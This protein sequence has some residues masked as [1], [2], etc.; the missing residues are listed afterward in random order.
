MAELVAAREAVL[1]A[2]L[3]WASWLAPLASGLAA[4]VLGERPR[5]QAGVA[6]ASWVLAGLL[7][8]PALAAV[9]SG[10]VAVDPWAPR[11]PGLGVFSLFLDGAS[12]PVAV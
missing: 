5:L 12:L 7:L 4:A 6:L 9:L 8:A 10:A 2:P 1:G 3:L 11:I